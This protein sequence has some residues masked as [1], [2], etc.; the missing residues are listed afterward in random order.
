[1]SRPSISPTQIIKV[2]PEGHDSSPD[3]LVT[4][5]PME[6]RLSFGAPPNREQKSISVTMRTPGNDFELALGFLYSEGIITDYAQVKEVRY[7]L[8]V[9]DPAETENVVLVYLSPEVEIDLKRLERHFYTSSSCGVCGKTSIEAVGA[10]GCSVFP[11]AQT[12]WV[13]A[14]LIHR[15][16]ELARAGQ[17]LFKHTGGIHAASLFDASGK[18][19]MQREDVGRHNAVDKII[20]ALLIQNQL[21]NA[22]RIMLV[23][24]RAGFELVQKTIAAGIPVMASVGA[25]S[26]LSVKLAKEFGLTL[27]GFVRDQ[28][29]NVYSDPGGLFSA[30]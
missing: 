23:S 26:S 1:M 30:G 25:P 9:K 19:L 4:E 11:V 24:G 12:S 14:E 27:L 22:N 2:S 13:S 28:R 8:E 3:L 18:L 7:C 29:F 21:D 10:A 17:T 20:G 5:E 16:P 6:I 15:L